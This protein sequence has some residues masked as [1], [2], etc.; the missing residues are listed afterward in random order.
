MSRNIKFDNLR[1][2]SIILIVM[3]HFIGSTH[4]TQTYFDFTYTLIYL[5]DLPLLIFISGYFSKNTPESS[6]KAFRTIFIPYIIFNTFWIIF[7]FL[8]CGYVPADIYFVP[9]FGLWYL[10]SLYFWRAF[11][12]T[13]TKIKHIF[14]ISFILAMLIGT[15]NL[16]SNFLS[17]TRTICYFPIFLFGFYFKDLEEKFTIK[18]SYALL[19]LIPLLI[20]ATLLYLP[21]NSTI[22]IIKYSYASLHMGNIKGTILRLLFILISMIIIIL[23]NNIMTHKK[24]FLTKIGKNS[25]SVYILQFYFVFT[26]PDIMNYLGLNYIFNST[27]LCIFYVIISTILVCFIL[28]RDKVQEI[29][30]ILIINVTKILMKKNSP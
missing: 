28:S 1:G 9:G 13:A 24:T 14:V 2:F 23:L 15:M 16:D 29:M 4:F 19:I 20:G 27:I 5:F 6:I 3:G 21:F 12:P 30:D 8:K 18:R 11:L 7:I 17:I 22:L 26:I 10:L 25:M